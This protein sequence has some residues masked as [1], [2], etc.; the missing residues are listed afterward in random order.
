MCREILETSYS[1]TFHLL[2]QKRS[3]WDSDR[4]RKEDNAFSLF[5][6]S[7]ELLSSA[8]ANIYMAEPTDLWLF[9]C[10]SGVG[11]NQKAET[12]RFQE[13][14]FWLACKPNGRDTLWLPLLNSP[15]S[16]YLSG[17]SEGQACP[18]CL[19]RAPVAAF[20][21]WTSSKEGCCLYFF[22]STTEEWET[23]PFVCLLLIHSLTK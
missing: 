17:C 18:V 5:F 7:N 11:C 1:T 21:Q 20:A 15:S 14:S 9:A 23:S 4:P 13:T 8:S 10:P 22:S 2:P 16:I 6:N 3:V 19:P 12:I